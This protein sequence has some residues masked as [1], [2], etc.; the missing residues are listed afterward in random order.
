M[1][2]EEVTTKRS[3]QRS[4]DYDDDET[5][6]FL[7]VAPLES[8]PD[9]PDSEEEDEGSALTPVMCA[10]E[11]GSFSIQI[12]TDDP[13]FRQKMAEIVPLQDE[14][15]EDLM[16]DPGM[17][18]GNQPPRVAPVTSASCRPDETTRTLAIVVS[19]SRQ[20][21]QGDII[22]TAGLDFANFERNPVVLWA[23]DLQRPP[24]GRVLQVR[25]TGNG[26]EALVEFADTPFAREVFSL[27]AG[28]YLSAWSIGF[29]PRRWERL[30]ATQGGGYHILE[31]EVVEISA[32]PVPA[33]PEALTK[34]LERAER[35]R[36]LRQRRGKSLSSLDACRRIG[37]GSAARGIAELLGRMAG[38]AVWRAAALRSAKSFGHNL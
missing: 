22:E 21:R 1:D 20:D 11:F 38:E 5:K 10:D 24:V 8:A 2:G 12:D 28:G 6:Q 7:S 14:S 35:S 33:N 4:A 37:L 9:V 23:H 32:V 26:V 18:V 36:Q 29:I 13:V 30:P 3:R 27:Y 19:T 17:V 34:A 16:D 25:K 15:E 31:A